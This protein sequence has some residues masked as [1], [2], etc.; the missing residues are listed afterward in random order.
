M[1]YVEFLRV[2]RAMIWHVGILA[3]VG[4][5]I[6]A[7]GQGTDVNIDSGGSTSHLMSGMAIPLG[8]LASIGMFYAAIFASSLGTSLNRENTTR[9][10][11]WTKPISR[12]LLAVRYVLIDLAGIIVIF[13]LTMLLVVGT[14]AYHHVTPVAGPDTLINFVLGIGVSV[15]WY[16]LLQVLTF[17]LPPGGRAAAGFLWPAALVG[18]GLA[19]INGTTGVIA[20]AID[21]INPLAYMGG[22]AFSAGSASNRSVFQGPLELRA[23][24]VWAF[25]AA[26]CAI[27]IAFWPKKEA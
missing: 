16:A 24:T 26:F 1:E 27:A 14:L 19:Q 11:S 6:L 22:V 12:T 2:R 20:R 4:L 17:A 25:A 23:L 13:A 18:A 10:V 21:I 15:M 7:F 8:A 9:E 3:V 5:V